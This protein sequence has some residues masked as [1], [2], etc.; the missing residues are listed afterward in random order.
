[1]NKLIT[2]EPVPILT[3]IKDIIIVLLSV[4]AIVVSVKTCSKQEESN[5]LSLRS[6]EIAKESNQIAKEANEIAKLA[7]NSSAKFDIINAET[8]WGMLKDSYDEIDQEVLVW[9]SKKGLKR[10]GKAVDSEEELAS[11]LDRLKVPPNI[12]RLYIKRHEKFQILKNVGE[13][14]KPFEERLANVN[15]VLPS[16]P[17]LPK[18]TLSGVS[19]S[20]FSIR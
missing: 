19:G 20:G 18:A 16:A 2:K 12:R 11:L 4:I 17:V 6:S 5:K 3:I 15:F 9:E 14:Y 8:Q 13:Q 7:M 10:D 1:M